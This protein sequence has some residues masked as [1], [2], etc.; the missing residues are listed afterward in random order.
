MN[1]TIKET[2]KV[3]DLTILDPYLDCEWTEHLIKD[4]WDD[5]SGEYVMSQAD[6]D[7]WQQYIVDYEADEKEIIYLAEKLNID[8]PE[9]YDRIKMAMVGL[10][11]S[12]DHKI[13]QAVL[14]ALRQ[15][16]CQ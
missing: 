3:V 6:Y 15:E 8:E 9:I 12:D 16:H 4:T 5:Q 7:Q 1:V 11:Y 13:T 14:Q 10:D 2:G